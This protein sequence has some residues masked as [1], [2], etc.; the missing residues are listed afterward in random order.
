MSMIM[1]RND[2]TLSAAMSALQ[3]IGGLQSQ[4]KAGSIL[5]M[6]QSTGLKEALAGNSILKENSG[7][8][9]MLAAA[10]G[11][12]GLSR[13]LNSILAISKPSAIPT[14]HLSII[15]AATDLG[16]GGSLQ[17]AV[18]A[19]RLIKPP[20]LSTQSA[21]GQAI[22]S[23]KS[24]SL[25]D[26]ALAGFFRDQTQNSAIRRIQSALGVT[27]A[28]L[29]LGGT[30]PVAN[31]DT[32]ARATQWSYEQRLL[33]GPVADLIRNARSGTKEQSS[34]MDGATLT[35]S[36]SWR[37]IMDGA[38]GPSLAGLRPGIVSA[39]AGLH[40]STLPLITR[41]SDFGLTGTA[42]SLAGHLAD[43]LARLQAEI[44]ELLEPLDSILSASR[45]PGATSQA[46]EAELEQFA[47]DTG[48]L[49][50]AWS[51]VATTGRLDALLQFIDNVL[52]T[53]GRNTAREFKTMGLFTLLM[54]VVAL[55]Q[56]TIWIHP[57]W[58]PAPDTTPPPGIERV[59][60]Q[61]QGLSAKF[62]ALTTQLAQHEASNLSDLP[63]V[64][65][66]RAALVRTGP[67]KMFPEVWRLEPGQVVG[68]R[69]KENGWMLVF[70]R[71]PLS[72]TV[73]S[74]WVYAQLLGT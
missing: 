72:G 22:E 3:S 2:D 34:L 20:A 65:V 25:R 49:E 9:T 62:D 46:T 38:M 12:G 32:I 10:S 33:G 24:K 64:H 27:G 31:G 45:E 71:D 67:G 50:Q 29:A 7:I 26:G 37:T 35:A 18:D 70:Y 23:L 4:V 28:L 59:L 11:T 68:V 41:A 15:K 66:K 16:F 6:L 44:S 30:L 36:A 39:Y 19:T 57:A 63:R 47:L 13:Q 43:N 40:R 73:G 42:S 52:S 1:K 48:K 8:A 74:G 54:V 17:S 53:F 61:Q 60:E 69:E 14:N 55:Y 51:E 5:E 21:V 56:S 58:T